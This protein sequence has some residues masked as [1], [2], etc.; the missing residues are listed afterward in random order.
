MAYVAQQRLDGYT[1]MVTH[2]IKRKAIFDKRVL[3]HKPGEVSFLEN[4]LV[5]I[6]RSNLDYTFK[7]DRKLLPK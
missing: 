4:Q 6:Y 3:A 7:T 5:Q 2:A 1:E